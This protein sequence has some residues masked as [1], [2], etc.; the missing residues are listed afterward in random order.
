MIR[1]GPPKVLKLL[2]DLKTSC[3]PGP[4]R[5][6]S[7]PDR[8]NSLGKGTMVCLQEQG[9]LREPTIPSL[10][11][12]PISPALGICLAASPFPS[13][14]LHAASPPS[15]S[16]H[17]SE[18]SQTHTVFY[19]P[20]LST[21]NSTVLTRFM[22]ESQERT[23]LLSSSDPKTHSGAL[24]CYHHQER[25]PGGALSLNSPALVRHTHFRFPPNF[26]LH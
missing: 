4:R 11:G 24:F 5:G 1:K 14:M 19:Q 20:L 18:F 12:L 17:S 2:L 15:T 21:Q 7:S 8:K 16:S 9:T 6:E 22:R 23:L 3:H 26:P 25:P 10:R 13:P